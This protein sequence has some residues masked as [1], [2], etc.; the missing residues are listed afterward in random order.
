MAFFKK[1]QQ[2]VS[3][4]WLSRNRAQKIKI[5]ISTFFIIGTIGLLI[6]LLNRPTYVPLYTDLDAKDAGDIV[7]KL[8]DE[9][10][11]Y[12]LADG[13]KSILVDPK[14][15]YKTRLMLAQEGLPKG[16]VMDFN[17]VFD[18]TKLGTTD[19]ERQLQYNQALQGELT[20]TIEEMAEVQ[21]ARIHIVQPEKSL[22]IETGTQSE[23]SAAVFLKLRPGAQINEEE[24]KG[25]INLISHSVEGMK[26]ENV[27]VIDDYGRLLSNIPLT[28]DE[29]SKEVI[30]SQLAIQ[31]NF[32]KQLQANVQSLLEQVFG[33]GNVVVRVSAKLN[34]DKKIVENKLFSPVNEDT[35]EGIVR[36]VQDLREHFTGTGNVPG[37]VPGVD[38]NVPGYQ[39]QNTGNSEYQKTDVT[40]NYEIN[41]S[42]ENLTV[43]PG[44]VDKLT[45]SVVIN[46]T[47]NDDEKDSISRLVGNAIGYD[48]QRDQISVEG[49]TFNN[50]LV[51]AM[52]DEMKNQEQQKA[53]RRNLMLIGAALLIVIL[54]GTFGLITVR[55]RRKSEEERIARELAEVQQAA[56]QQA[57]SQTT[58]N[59]GS[60]FFANIEKLAR[61]KPEDV[62]KVLKSWLNED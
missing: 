61:R 31:N 17:D 16:G 50:D 13:G 38:T 23:P 18:K 52:T 39:Q 43:A 27:T 46:R 9:K 7:N 11:A 34:F 36:S 58:E 2:Q 41:E 44:A 57:A 14:Q 19:W 29:S 62:A 53:A 42:H 48:S 20:R 56:A 33:P 32:Q 6:F 51:T 55:R 1:I 4:F 24:V 45:V 15:V 26:P 25:I 30:N 8:E 5:S 40:R 28:Q 10:I 49:M 59:T 3:D 22:F 54:F 60:E 21:S 47:L 12:K 35:G 37:G